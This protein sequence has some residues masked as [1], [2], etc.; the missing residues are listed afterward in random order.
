MFS[1]RRVLVCETPELHWGEAMQAYIEAEIARSRWIYRVLDGIQE[2]EKVVFS[3]DDYMIIP[4]RDAMNDNRVLN[5]M[6]IFKDRGLR[7]VRDLRGGHAP[8]LREVQQKLK[9]MLPH[10]DFMTYFHKPASVWQLHLHVAAPCDCIRTTN[11]SQKVLFLEDCLSCMEVDADFFK[12]VTM[13]YMV[14]SRHP[15]AQLLG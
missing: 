11:D 3:N 15:V 13:T 10:R 5:W 9:E 2:A 8:M 4:D 1:R 7:S 12:K 6:V 14:N